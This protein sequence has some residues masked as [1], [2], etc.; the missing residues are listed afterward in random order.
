MPLTLSVQR[1]SPGCLNAGG[2]ARRKVVLAVDDLAAIHRPRLDSKRVLFS[3]GL[4]AG[5][6]NPS[7]D[8]TVLGILPRRATDTLLRHLNAL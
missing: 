2:P 3:V 4:D 8:E 1:V 7:R 5:H 6:T